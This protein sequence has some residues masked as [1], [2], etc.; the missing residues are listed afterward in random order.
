M[1]DHLESCPRCEAVLQ[2][3]DACTDPVVA[4]LRKPVPPE[5]AQGSNGRKEAADFPDPTARE[6]WPSLPGYEILAVLG[7]GG[8]GVVSIVRGICASTAWWR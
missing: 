8:M 3:L 1:A 2:T 6:H 5:D 4:A 7:K